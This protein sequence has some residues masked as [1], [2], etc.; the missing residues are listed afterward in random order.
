MNAIDFGNGHCA[1]NVCIMF[2]KLG[3]TGGVLSSPT[4]VPPHLPQPF[5]TVFP[6]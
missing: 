1:Q 6:P 4:F 2:V 5:F 3:D